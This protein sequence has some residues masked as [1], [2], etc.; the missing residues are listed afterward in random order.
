LRELGEYQLCWH[1]SGK[2]KVFQA[3]IFEY[4]RQY[5]KGERRC[6][7]V[8]H[9]LDPGSNL[10]IEKILSECYVAWKILKS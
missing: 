3:N 4:I 6:G 9:P 10:S 5:L 2:G 1:I 8:V 7:R